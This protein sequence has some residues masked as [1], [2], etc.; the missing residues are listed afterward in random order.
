MEKISRSIRDA[1]SIIS[2]VP[3]NSSSSLSLTMKD[4]AKNPTEFALVSSD[5]IWKLAITEGESSPVFLTSDSAEIA[6]LE[7]L[8][9]SYE[10]TPGTIMARMTIEFHNP[11]EREEFE[12][13]RTFYLTEN[14]RK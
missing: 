8:N 10:N 6:E 4:S 5:G 11:L 12:F 3:G 13:E 9:A 14:V 2:P 7:F 1:D